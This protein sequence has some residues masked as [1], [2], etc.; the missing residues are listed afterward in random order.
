M[1]YYVPFNSFPNVT[2]LGQA[3][4]ND[5]KNKHTHTYTGEIERERERN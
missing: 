2:T 3:K 5:E 4:E 1:H